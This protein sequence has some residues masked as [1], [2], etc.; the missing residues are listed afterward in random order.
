MG[1][2]WTESSSQAAEMLDYFTTTL[3]GETNETIEGLRSIAMN[4]L[5]SAGYGTPQPWKQ[6]VK[7]SE[8]RYKL[9][10]VD[11]V[12]VVINN[13]IA[14]AVLPAG[15]FSLPIMPDTVQRIGVGLQEFPVRTKEMLE[16]ERK[17]ASSDA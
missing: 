1:L 12:S 15:I 14:V 16:A 11:A 2:V 10:Y 3:G 13:I 4:V 7:A 9:S 6:D 8:S 17:S 5:G